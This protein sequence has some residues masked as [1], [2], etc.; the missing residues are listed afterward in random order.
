MFTTC[1]DCGEEYEPDP[2]G[3]DDSCPNCGFGPD[4]C[5]HSQDDRVNEEIYDSAQGENIEQEF[6]GK[7]GL[8]TSAL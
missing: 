5:E 6:C 7:C 8:D 1:G 2:L 3:D 4:D